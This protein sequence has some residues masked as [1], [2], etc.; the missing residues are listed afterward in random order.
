MADEYREA[1]ADAKAEKA[2]A[3]SLRPWWKKKRFILPIVLIV[4]VIGVSAGSSGTSDDN[5]RS[6]V[7]SGAKN[8]FS[9]NRENPP[10]AD[11]EITSCEKTV[12]DT[13]EVGLRVTNN[14]SKESDYMI[15]LTV[16]DASGSKIGD[17]FAS[18]SNVDAGQ[19]A[20]IDGVATLTGEGD[21][22][23]CS[24]EEVERFAS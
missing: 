1:K 15:T 13:V 12:I 17:G 23:E 24:V 16:E 7:A 10:E 4:I 5:D 14:S 19:T 20:N 8:D 22:F 6:D 18:T 21:D 11:V 9:T 3:K 2:R